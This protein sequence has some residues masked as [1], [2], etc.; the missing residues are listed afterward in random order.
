MVFDREIIEPS[1]ID[2]Q[3]QTT[4][5]LLDKYNKSISLRF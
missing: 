5:R 3:I 2:V 1:I 4:I